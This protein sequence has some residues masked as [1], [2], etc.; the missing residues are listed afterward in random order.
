MRI[1]LC[2]LAIA[3]VMLSAP[4]RADGDDAGIPEFRNYGC[5]SLI[6][7]AI[8]GGRD[9]AEGVWRFVPDGA[10]FAIVREPGAFSGRF[11]VV[12]L[13]SPDMSI[14]PGTEVG[15]AARTAVPG[16]YDVR[17][18][19]RPAGSRRLMAG[20][21]DPSTFI[22]EVDPSGRLTLTGY[23]RGKRVKINR[24]LPYFFRLRVEDVDTRPQ[25][26]DGAVRLAPDPWTD[27]PVVL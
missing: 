25:G 15:S 6:S 20:F 12:V 5:D 27:L 26:L 23:R 4:L 9:M 21:S 8:H 17:L 3:A 10:V 24:W 18:H 14:P 22:M 2:L 19:L 16:K 1:S 7:A 11:R 13:D